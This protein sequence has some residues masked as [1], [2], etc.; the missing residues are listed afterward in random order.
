VGQINHSSWDIG[1]DFG[2]GLDVASILHN[3]TVYRLLKAKGLSP[4]GAAGSMH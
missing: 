2:K 4:V 3:Q 1:E